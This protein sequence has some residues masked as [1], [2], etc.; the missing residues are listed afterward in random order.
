MI[1]STVSLRFQLQLAAVALLA[2]GLVGCGSSSA[3]PAVKRL[4]GKW[5][6]AMVVYEDVVADKLSPEQIDALKQQQM[7]LEFT[8]DGSMV[9][10]GAVGGQAQSNAGRW[11]VVSEEG[12][13][14]S[15]ETEEQGGKKA[16]VNIEFDGG[17]TFYIPLHIQLKPEVAE[18]A[19]V[20]AMK[21]TRVR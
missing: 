4:P 5:Q 10:S 7:G 13:L 15:I 17:D 12:D 9:T 19:E 2:A 16:Q 21:F 14:L 18:V 3:A 11:Q 1:A 6:G 20:G 8:S